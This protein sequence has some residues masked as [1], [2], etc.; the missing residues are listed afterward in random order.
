M[1]GS[2]PRNHYTHNAIKD[3]ELRRV[4]AAAA[5]RNVG[6]PALLRLQQQ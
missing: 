4:F 2:S 6:A 1:A 5:R 3:A